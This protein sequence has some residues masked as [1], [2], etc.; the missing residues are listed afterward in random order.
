MIAITTSSSI[1]VKPSLLVRGVIRP[2]PSWVLSPLAL[3]SYNQC[4]GKKP[5]I[6]DEFGLGSTENLRELMKTIRE[7]NIA[8]GLM[9]SI[10][11]HRRDGGWYYHNEGGTP[12]SSFHIP[13]FSAGFGNDEIKILELLRKEALIN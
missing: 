3:E 11:S 9:W 12:V 1:S 6:I 5:L 7:S 13:G 8:G 4:K 10:R 2:Q